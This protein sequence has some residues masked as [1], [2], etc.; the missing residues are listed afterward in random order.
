MQ[1]LN[2]WVLSMWKYIWYHYRSSPISGGQQHVLRNDEYL[3]SDKAKCWQRHA[4]IMGLKVVC[5][6]WKESNVYNPLSSSHSPFSG[7]AKHV[8]TVL[9]HTGLLRFYSKLLIIS[10]NPGTLQEI[11][12]NVFVVTRA[13]GDSSECWVLVIGCPGPECLL[14]VLS[15]SKGLC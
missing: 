10:L 7:G 1:D 15:R 11:K 8:P 9:M 5:L 2:T 13:L 6:F 12:D 14:C 4:A 3:K